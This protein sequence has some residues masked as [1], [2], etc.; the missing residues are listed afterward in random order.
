MTVKE[1]RER[2]DALLNKAEFTA[3]D[4]KEAERLIAELEKN[5]RAWKR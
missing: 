4:Y 2:L 5:E 3:E 1:I